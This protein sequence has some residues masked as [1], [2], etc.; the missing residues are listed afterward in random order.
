[1]NK[2]RR[3][4]TA[5]SEEGPEKRPRLDIFGEVESKYN[6]IV[7][8]NEDPFSL[9]LR[10]YGFPSLVSMQPT[11][12]KPRYKELQSEYI[13]IM[14]EMVDNDV[15]T[16][17]EIVCREAWKQLHAI[18]ETIRVCKEVLEASFK[19][20][21]IRSGKRGYNHPDITTTMLEPMTYDPINYHNAQPYQRC[22]MELLTCMRN[23]QVRRL[24]E[25]LYKEVYTKDGEPTYAWA[26][27]TTIE[28]F[29]RK[30]C[31]KDTDFTR[32]HTLYNEKN[33]IATAISQLTKIEDDDVPKVEQHRQMFSFNNGVYFAR[34]NRFYEYPD[35]PR[36]FKDTGTSDKMVSAK[37]FA[38][39]FNPEWVDYP[40]PM[41]I[42]T[43][44][45][46]SLLKYQELDYDTLFW[47][48]ALIGKLLYQLHD[49][50]LSEDW[51]VV[52][53]LYGSGGT[54]KSTIMNLIQHIYEDNKVH[55]FGETTEE[56]FGLQTAYEKWIWMVA[57]MKRGFK[58]AQ[59]QYQSITAGEKTEIA[60][61][62][63]APK[64][65]VW[66]VPGIIAGNESVPYKD[67]SGQVARR[68]V[69]VQMWRTVIEQDSTLR[70]Q[71]KQE[72]A[73]LICKFNRCYRLAVQRHGHQGLWDKGVL[74]Q[75]FWDQR[76]KF[77]ADSNPLIG[78]LESSQVAFGKEYYTQSIDLVGQYMQYVKLNKLK[79][80]EWKE[81]YYAGP[82]EKYGIKIKRGI[83]DLELDP[84]L[85]Y[86]EIG[87]NSNTAN[88]RCKATDPCIGV[89]I[90]GFPGGPPAVGAA[91]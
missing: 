53:F 47:V 1:M 67:T 39:D 29:V 68:H 20:H 2:R 60:V 17:D 33:S 41:K 19:I 25:D 74:P 83:L 82:F 69:I 65:I 45:F 54:G 36:G 6:N 57:E 11:E 88:P 40:D 55:V 46:E 10:L 72:I 13:V 84:V 51:Q 71:M 38:V 59:G 70:D 58:M 76:S 56:R 64:N 73:A 50:D 16:S 90:R 91:Q 89:G 49:P 9:A 18:I 52:L 22:L 8:T 14:K 48:Y 26:K 85:G 35:V 42:D 23:Q 31:S 75:Y 62:H 44:A 7:N 28:R 32:F 27:Y 24:D 66:E 63:G 81:E 12:I 3:T 34:H 5:S 30:N 15:P 43:S 87:P 78:F 4:E 37:F 21:R 79:E 86:Q 61:K 80:C 77:Q